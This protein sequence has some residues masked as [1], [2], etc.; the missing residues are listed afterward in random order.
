MDVLNGS[1]LLDALKRCD[2]YPYID[3][4]I[5]LSN[6]WDTQELIDGLHNE[7]RA[8]RLNDWK[9]DRGMTRG[10]AVFQSARNSHI[11]ILNAQNPELLR[12][13]RLHWVLFENGIGEDAFEALSCMECLTAPWE[14]VSDSAEL[15][16]FLCSFKIV[17]N[18]N[19]V[20]K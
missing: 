1:T 2:E 20:R 10:K 4:C 14:R 9:I 7:I 3:V 15:D 8:H 18:M 6:M 13:Y 16:D 5:A 19:L 11:Y 12:G 17:P